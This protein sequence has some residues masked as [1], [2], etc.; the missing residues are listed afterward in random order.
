M[1]EISLTLVL[2][3]KSSKIVNDLAKVSK[4]SEYITSFD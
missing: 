3:I 2:Q 1:S 4:K